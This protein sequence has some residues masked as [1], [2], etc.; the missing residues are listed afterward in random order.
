LFFAK[1]VPLSIMAIINTIYLKNADDIFIGILSQAIE[2]YLPHIKIIDDD[3]DADLAITIDDHNSDMKIGSIL[4]TIEAEIF[5]ASKGKILT[6]G[7]YHLEWDT[8]QFSWADKKI[9]LSDRERDVLAMLMKAGDD[10]CSRSDLLKK[11]WGY[12]PD[13]DTHALET[14]IYRLRQK[15]EDTP[16]N[17]KYLITIE[18][19]YRLD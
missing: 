16:E 15:L 19:G 5:N 14:H 18:G 4:D 10:G 12:N 11:I 9:I 13:I 2:T 8:G 7:M 17:P 1:A 3:K 6:H